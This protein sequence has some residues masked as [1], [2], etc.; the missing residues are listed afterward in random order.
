MKFQNVIF[1]WP[2]KFHNCVSSLRQD[3]ETLRWMSGLQPSWTNWH[4]LVSCPQQTA[5]IHPRHTLGLAFNSTVSNYSL[6]VSAFDVL[7]FQIAWCQF[8][9]SVVTE[10]FF[11]KSCPR[12]NKNQ[13]LRLVS[14]EHWSPWEPLGALWSWPGW[15]PG[16]A[17]LCTSRI[18]VG[19]VPETRLVS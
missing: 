5:V 8:Y 14:G 7:S 2:Q 19:A 15:L 1:Q 16:S 11:L 12:S 3:L 4:L 17:W 10:G 9:F 18:V 6:V 13:A